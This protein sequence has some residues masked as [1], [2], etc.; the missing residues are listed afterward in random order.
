MPTIP[1]RAES[2]FSE[3]GNEGVYYAAE[4]PGLRVDGPLPFVR[5]AM[6]E[7]F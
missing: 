4:I 1:V 5:C 7:H 3:L 2:V 6:L